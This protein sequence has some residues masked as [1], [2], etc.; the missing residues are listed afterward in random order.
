M[1]EEEED[2][3]HTSDVLLRGA[4]GVSERDSS[5]AGRVGTHA[6][7]GDREA[8]ASVGVAA[9]ERD[10]VACPGGGKIAIKGTARIVEEEQR[11]MSGRHGAREATREDARVRER[12]ENEN[13]R[14]RDGCTEGLE[15]EEWSRRQV[16]SVS[17]NAFEQD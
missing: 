10:I 6:N 3:A 15:E 1:S 11:S 12:D 5:R 16:R 8:S 4:R 7:L 2:E 13:S 17:T 14:Q 9:L